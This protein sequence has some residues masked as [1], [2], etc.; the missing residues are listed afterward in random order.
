M[1]E[2][3]IYFLLFYILLLNQERQSLLKPSLI[4]K[5]KQ[6]LKAKYYS[7]YQQ[8]KS[9]PSNISFSEELKLPGLYHLLKHAPSLSN[10]P[11]DPPMVLIL[12]AAQ[13]LQLCLSQPVKNLE[14][15]QKGRYLD[16]TPDVCCIYFIVKHAHLSRCRHSLITTP[17]LFNSS[18][19]NYVSGQRALPYICLIKCHFTLLPGYSLYYVQAQCYFF[20]LNILIP[21]CCNYSTLA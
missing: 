7:L 10:S 4:Y 9:H 12:A 6:I 17:G 1:R 19:D 11:L 21:S 5:I 16:H 13:L 18:K 20:P 8:Q 3:G 14:A 15:F 2:E